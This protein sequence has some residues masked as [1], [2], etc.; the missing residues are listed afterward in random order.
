[1]SFVC[2]FL[3]VDSK[4]RVQWVL[5]LISM[6]HS[7]MLLLCLQCRSLSKK[8]NLGN[9]LFV[10]SIWIMMCFTFQIQFQECCV[11]C[12][13][14]FESFNPW[15]FNVAHWWYQEKSCFIYAICVLFLFFVF[16]RQSS[17]SVSVVFIFKLSLSD[18]VPMSPI[19]FSFEWL[20]RQTKRSQIVHV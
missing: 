7:M 5:C 3:C 15:A 6:H 11:D 17:S 18:V 8:Y 20:N 4:D 16:S 2:C 9:C 1:M 12:Q 10:S 14:F 13:S 19:L